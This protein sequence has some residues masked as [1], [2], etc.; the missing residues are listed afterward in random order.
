MRSIWTSLQQHRPRLVLVLSDYLAFRS[1]FCVPQCLVT[2]LSLPRPIGDEPT[3]GGRA[4]TGPV[5]FLKEDTSLL[6]CL[7]IPAMSLKKDIC[8]VVNY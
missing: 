5:A 7:I 4:H 6:Q 2:E 8:R 3:G 1:L